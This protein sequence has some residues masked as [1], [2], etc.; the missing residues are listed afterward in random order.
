MTT[1]IKLIVMILAL[2]LAG[3][4][5]Q[6]IQAAEFDGMFL[7]SCLEQRDDGSVKNSVCLGFLRGLIAGL[8]GGSLSETKAGGYCPPDKVIPPIKRA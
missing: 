6:S 4:Y 1:I 7:Q 5:V 2:V 3:H 8:K